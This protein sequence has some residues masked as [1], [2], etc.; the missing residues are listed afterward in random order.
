MGRTHRNPPDRGWLASRPMCTAMKTL[1]EF[2]GRRRRWVVAFWIVLVIVAVP[3]AM[4]QTD[5]LTGGGF[6]VPGS[7]SQK[8]GAALRDDFGDQTNALSVLLQASPAAGE[9]QRQA[10]VGRVRRTIAA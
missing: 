6:D 1:A 9:A 8:A 3:F 10:A 5:H 4:K 2:L 7:Q